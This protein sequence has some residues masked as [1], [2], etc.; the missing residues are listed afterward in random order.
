MV[1]PTKTFAGR[2]PFEILSELAG[3]VAGSLC[4]DLIGE[5]RRLLDHVQGFIQPFQRDAL[6]P[7][8]RTSSK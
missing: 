7:K 8:N 5:M 1:A 4:Q 3:D 2:V 6:V